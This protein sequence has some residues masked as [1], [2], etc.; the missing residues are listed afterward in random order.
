MSNGMEKIKVTP[1]QLL[2]L[3]EKMVEAREPVLV[4]GAPGIGKTDLVK[5]AAKNAGYKLIITHPVVSDPTDYKGLPALVNQDY[6]RSLVTMVIRAVRDANTPMDQLMADIQRFTPDPKAEFIPIGDLRKLVDADEPTVFF[7]DDVGQATVATQAALMQLLLAREVNGKKISDMVTFIAATNRREDKAGVQGILE[8]V[9]SRFTMI[10]ELTV[11]NEDWIRWALDPDRGNMPADLIAFIRWRPNMLFD[12]Q[13][14]RDMVN[15][16]NPR[17][18]AAVGRLRKAELPEE[19]QY[20]AYAGAAGQ[21]FAAEFVGFLRVWMNLPDINYVINNPRAAD[22]P[23]D[24]ATKYALCGALASRSTEENFANVMLYAN[25]LED[26]FSVLLVKDAVL[27]HKPL[28]R[29]EVFVEW[30]KKHQHV[31]TS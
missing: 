20:P 24:P 13:P 21:G 6:F 4:V 10:L 11:D 3:L 16:P 23:E 28:Q 29:T 17:T 19:V 7:M 14:T 25:R 18:V 31:I 22:I 15:T 1:S 27:R 12:F 26:E 5:E 2:P 8:P 9:K 30:I